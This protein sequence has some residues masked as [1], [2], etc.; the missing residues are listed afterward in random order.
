MKHL[1]LALLICAMPM[2]L[3][4]DPCPDDTTPPVIVSNGDTWDC[5]VNIFDDPDSVFITVTEESECGLRVVEM[6]RWELIKGSCSDDFVKEYTIVWYAEDMAGNATNFTQVITIDRPSIEE[7]VFPQDTMIQCPASG[8]DNPELYGQPMINGN[9]LQDMCGF[10]VK[11][12]IL[13]T[14]PALNAEACL[15]EVRKEW[16]I[17]D[18]CSDIILK[19]TQNLVLIDTLRPIIACTSL[20]DTVELVLDEGSC[21]VSYSFPEVGAIDFCAADEDLVFRYMINDQITGSEVSL[22]TGLYKGSVVVT[23]PCNNSD[24]CYYTIIVRDEDPP[25]ISC[26]ETEINL[27]ESPQIVSVDELDLVVM[28]CTDGIELS[29][30]FSTQS[31]DESASSQ[32]FTCD[33]VTGA[34]V[35]IVVVA[36][37]TSGN[38][39]NQLNCEVSVTADDLICPTRRS[40]AFHSPDKARGIKNRNF[41]AYVNGQRLIVESESSMFGL[42]LY[43][44]SGQLVWQQQWTESRQ[45]FETDLPDMTSSG[46]Y[47][48]KIAQGNGQ[49]QSVSLSV[50]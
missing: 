27:T 26:G 22:M 5:T 7:V 1:I 42:A 14:L 2:L 3:N 15:T 49:F 17:I 29:Y 45:R 35:D 40:T 21:T 36:I 38:L 13:D 16:T 25:M 48:L 20:K 41:K 28:D 44:S 10:R 47:F 8:Y 9:P 31:A 11:W 19:D 32:T 18:Q 12:L 39:S 23:D 30:R 50:F 37:D 24:T 34:P 6:A 33:M 43:N 46:L 4:A